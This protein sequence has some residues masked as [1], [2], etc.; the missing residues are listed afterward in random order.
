[1]E[2]V[3][4]LKTG[5]VNASGYNLITTARRGDTRL[6]TVLLGAGSKGI[7]LREATRMM[8]S[9]FAAARQKNGAKP[10]AAKPAAKKGPAR[11][12]GGKAQRTAS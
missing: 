12:A 4:G 7:R 3:D 1:M 11:T 10:A 8:E 9:G 2:G 6:V 5:Y